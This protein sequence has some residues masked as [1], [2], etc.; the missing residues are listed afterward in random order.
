[1]FSRL[2]GNLGFRRNV[3]PD[4]LYADIPVAEDDPYRYF[5]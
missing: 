1:M 2:K 4:Y 3:N 5:H